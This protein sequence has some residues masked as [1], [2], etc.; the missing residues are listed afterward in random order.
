MHPAFGKTYV[1]ATSVREF[2]TSI[3]KPRIVAYRYNIEE[4]IDQVCGG[5]M[6][7]SDSRLG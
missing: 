5:L 4:S 7:A 6:P 1:P 3:D 2:V